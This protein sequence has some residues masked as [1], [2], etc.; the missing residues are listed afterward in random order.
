[1]HPPDADA[2]ANHALKAVFTCA[3]VKQ[4][5]VEVFTG[6]VNDTTGGPVTVKVAE[7]VAVNGS[8]LLVYVNV[9]V[10]EPPQE[11]GAPVL[12]LVMTTLQPPV[13]DAVANQAAN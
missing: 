1:L 5:A 9:T 4:A 7:Q 13:D 3:C 2:V 12:S 11:D 10:V 6:Q 8:Q